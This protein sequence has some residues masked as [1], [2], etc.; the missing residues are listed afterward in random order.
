MYIATWTWSTYVQMLCTYSE[1]YICTLWMYKQSYIWHVQHSSYVYMHNIAIRATTDSGS[2]ASN[3]GLL[4]HVAYLR[5]KTL[6]INLM[7]VSG[8]SPNV[9]VVS[10]LPLRGHTPPRTGFAFAYIT[11]HHHRMM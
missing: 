8:F 2:G 11:N 10:L 3:A 4:K 6:V 5:I 9:W 1:L 7:L